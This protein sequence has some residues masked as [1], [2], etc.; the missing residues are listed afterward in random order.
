MV[1]YRPITV[2]VASKR[3][4]AAKRTSNVEAKIQ[5]TV[6]WKCTQTTPQYDYCSSSKV[7]ER[8]RQKQQQQQNLKQEWFHTYMLMPVCMFNALTALA[9]LCA[10]FTI[11]CN[12]NDIVQ[13]RMLT[14]NARS[15]RAFEMYIVENSRGKLQH[16]KI[17]SMTELS[18]FIVGK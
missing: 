7:V 10:F 12:S 18:Q 3:L 5:K 14:F 11:L 9:L 4:Q 15:A 13:Y 1:N 8:Q 2:L 17:T 16:V 6:G